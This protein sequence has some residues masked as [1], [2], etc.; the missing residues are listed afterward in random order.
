MLQK[1]LPTLL[2][3]LLFQA[4]FSYGQSTFDGFALYNKLNNY[5]SYLVDKDG[6]IAHSWNCNVPGNYAVMLKENGN[7]IRGG[8]YSGNVLNGAAVGGMVQEIDP[9]GNVVW[10]FIYSDATH[11][12][13]HDMAI[14]PNGNVLLTAWEV[15]NST[16]LQAA[17]YTGN[18]QTKYPTHFVEV[19]QNGTGGQIVWEWHMWDHM[20]QDK[21]TN[22]PNYGVIVD[23]P[24]LMNINVQTSGSMGGPGGGGDWF[25]VNGI[26]YNPDLDQIVFSSRYLSEIFII[27]HSTT[28]AEAAGH[29]GGNA[30]K[31]GDFLFRWGKPANFGGSGLQ[32]IPGPVHDTRWIKAGRPNAG[33]IQFFNNQGSSGNS[34]VDA[35]EPP[36]V[37]YNYTH[38]A[39]QAYLPA[40][41]NWRHNCFSNAAGQS[42]SD[43]LPNGNTFV[44]LSGGYMYEVD[45]N[46][47]LVWQYPEGPAKAFRYTCDDPG[48]I[49]LLGNTPCTV[50]GLA[51]ELQDFTIYPNPSNG[52]FRL[53]G[54]PAGTAGLEVWDLTGQLISRQQNPL[55]L[56]LSNQPDGIYFIHLTTENGHSL[57]RKISLQK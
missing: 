54:M 7:I 21:D 43:R 5:S 2:V 28:T 18:S 35:I 37:G 40:T 41:Y 47:V 16:E 10:Q 20:V 3:A 49:A 29:T 14:L 24:E 31:G 45:S 44:N 11:V 22:K 57:T 17:G 6:N 46:N 19:Q 25:H 23:H 27:D 1:F 52:V 42:A 8:V 32:Q 15:K 12:S 48:I 55:Q 39:G 4:T 50:L 13:H 38:T 34:T 26:D 9:N 33:L 51:D 36:R 30:G 53:G 56:D